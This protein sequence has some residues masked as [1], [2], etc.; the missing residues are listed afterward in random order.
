MDTHY[1]LFI[2]KSFIYELMFQKLKNQIVSFFHNFIVKK[3]RD[4]INTSNQL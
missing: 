2:L 4:L 1:I 3:I